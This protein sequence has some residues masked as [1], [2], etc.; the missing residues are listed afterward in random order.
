MVYGYTRLVPMNQSAQKVKQG[1]YTHLAYVRFEHA[2]CCG[3]LMTTYDTLCAWL[4]EQS[5][6]H[7]Y[8]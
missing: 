8:Q 4:V 1:A 3:S 2:A 7:W 6:V 5:L